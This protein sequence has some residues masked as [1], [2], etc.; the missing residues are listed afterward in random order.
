MRYYI[1]RASFLLPQRLSENRDLSAHLELTA[2]IK[3][4]HHFLWC[5]TMPYLH[6]VSLVILEVLST[7][8]VIGFTS[9]SSKW[10]RSF[11]LMLV[12]A[13]AYISI[14]NT[15]RHVPSKLWSSVLA[16]NAST[17]LLRYVDLVLL[18]SWSFDARGPTTSKRHPKE[19]AEKTTPQLGGRMEASQPPVTSWQRLEFG[20]SVT[21]NPRQLNTPHQV[22]NVPRWSHH[23]PQ[24]VP[25]RNSFLRRTAIS[26]VISYMIVDLCS[27][28][29]QPERNATLFSDDKVALFTLFE[30]L[31]FEE[32]VIRA[33]ASF[34]LWLN[35]FCVFKIFHGLL[36]ILA[37]G[38]GFSEV[39]DWPPPFGPLSEA[40][41]VRRFWGY[42]EFLCGQTLLKTDTFVARLNNVV[43]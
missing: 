27:L 41:S 21:L 36:V 40:Y 10:V 1:S 30:S 35:V 23:E 14:S 4:V 11:G 19:I 6:P 12:A 20:L 25:S 7:G 9:A 3:T 22:K 13:S 39:R 16:G 32:I 42:V 33:I 37:V 34:M 2:S 8:V 5:E 31:E 18:D 29:A 17:Y 24:H 15:V 26:V 28:G 43:S 38:S